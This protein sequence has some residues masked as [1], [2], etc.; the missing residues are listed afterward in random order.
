M[1]FPYLALQLTEHNCTGFSALCPIGKHLR[2][3]DF[4]CLMARVSGPRHHL[5]RGSFLRLIRHRSPYDELSLLSFMFHRSCTI[6]S[7]P[8]ARP[9]RR[10]TLTDAYE[11]VVFSS[12]RAVHF[13]HNRLSVLPEVKPLARGRGGPALGRPAAS[14][15]SAGK[16]V[17]F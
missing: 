2:N 5:F 4:S 8:D 17:S 1:P 9:K 6:F 3:G 12:L 15:G 11:A 16:G 13:R 14:P 7:S 10:L